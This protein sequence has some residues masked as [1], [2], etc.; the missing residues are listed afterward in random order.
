MITMV[1]DAD[2]SIHLTTPRRAMQL[3]LTGTTPQ[4]HEPNSLK[5]NREY[6]EHVGVA[7]SLARAHSSR[8]FPTRLSLPRE[9]DRP[10]PLS[11][12]RRRRPPRMPMTPTRPPTK[13]IARRAPLAGSSAPACPQRYAWR[14]GPATAHPSD[15]TIRTA[16]TSLCWE[17]TWAR[18]V[19]G[20]GHAWACA[21][22]SHMVGWVCGNGGPCNGIGRT[23]H[24][25]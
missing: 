19:G 9:T 15:P 11:L 24:Q 5:R 18:D 20:G 6:Y 10:A 12:C 13:R 21:W 16:I 7:L 23:W 4:Q 3:D 22:A 14:P 1:N 17:R 8:S 25:T 2:C